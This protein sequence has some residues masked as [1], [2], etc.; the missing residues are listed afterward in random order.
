ML[1]STRDV[2]WLL[3]AA[4]GIGF[5]MSRFVPARFGPA[6]TPTPIAASPTP[7]ASPTPPSDDPRVWA[8][9]IVAGCAGDAADAYLVS[10]GGG[11][12]RFDGQ[13]WYL[14]DDTLRTLR[15][16][17][18]VPGLAIAAG[19][20]SRLVRID[21]SA[22]TVSPELPLGAE[23]VYAIEALN[24]GSIVMAGS[25]LT[26]RLFVNGHWEQIGGGGADVQAWRAILMR[27]AKEI[28]FAGDDGSL[29]LFDGKQFVDRSITKGPR[30]TALSPLGSDV[31]VGAEDGSLYT[32]SAA[33]A[34][35]V[36]GHA[37]G[38]VK[39]LAPDGTGAY[40]LA[41]DLTRFGTA[42]P[43]PRDADLA[44]NGLSCTVINMFTN[45]RGEL[46]LIARDGG[47]A[48]V[49]RYDGV[50]TKWGHC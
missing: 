18:C 38:A 49:A 4:I 20:G 15:T 41:D 35:H 34:P 24:A 2:A 42:T 21:P 37:K 23:D 28:W 1:K 29:V 47:R 27:S 6:S 3:V 36:V 22:L 46:W 12:A 19:D 11:I 50:W 39:A 14:V 48:G 43:A 32:V 44:A 26:I 7:F 45:V 25:A 13:F 33:A 17:T 40:V 30:F 16:V 8:Q 10:F 9:P 31:L 5:L